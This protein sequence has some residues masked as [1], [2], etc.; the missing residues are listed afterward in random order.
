MSP[1]PCTVCTHRERATIDTDLVGGQPDKRVAAVYGIGAASVRRHRLNHIPKFLVKAQETREVSRAGD[2]LAQIEAI[3]A[4]TLRI[5]LDADRAGDKRTALYA[6]KEARNNLE[7]MAKLAGELRTGTTV[8]ILVMPEW[9]DLRTQ[10][11]NAV[12]PYPEAKRAIAEV[13][14]HVSD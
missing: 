11:L 8:N 5:L 2:L 3:Q 4:K 14:A 12:D 7:L 10:I 6:I 1:Q 9:I 13:V